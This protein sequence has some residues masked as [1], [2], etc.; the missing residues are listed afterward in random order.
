MQY[1]SMNHNMVANILRIGDD[2]MSSEL[3][4][5]NPFLTASLF[6]AYMVII[7]RRP[8]TFIIIEKK[9]PCTVRNSHIQGWVLIRTNL[10]W[11]SCSRQQESYDAKVNFSFTSKYI[12]Q[13]NI[14]CYAIKMR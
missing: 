13:R 1:L 9:T 7:C 14:K 5:R 11:G 8:E 2:V 6:R 12:I 10:F 4:V 3:L